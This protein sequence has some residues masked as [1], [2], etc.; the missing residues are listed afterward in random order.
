VFRAEGTHRG[1][2]VQRRLW[3]RAMQGGDHGGRRTDV[4]DE[5]GSPREGASPF[6]ALLRWWRRLIP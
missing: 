4:L 2:Q 5:L 1:G 3:H 6:D